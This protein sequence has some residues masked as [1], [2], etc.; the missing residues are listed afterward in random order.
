MTSIDANS[1]LNRF[2]TG[3][4]EYVFHS[5]L[6]VVDTEL[7]DYVSGLLVRFTRCE[8]LHR[9]RQ[10]DGKPTTEV[11]AMVV[12]AENRLGEARREV[13]RHIGDYTLF[14]SGIY[15]EALREMRGA[16]SRDQFINYCAQGKRAYRIASSIEGGSRAAPSSLL[17]R[18]SE[19]FEMCAYGLREIRRE[20][21]RRDSEGDGNVP[22]VL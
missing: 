9:I 7:I 2:F 20:W 15:P 5:H 21:E 12:E 11:V 17:E 14:W 19:Q 16:D 13:H 8:T 4:S 3:L 22:L 10:I 18:M 6:G 1:T